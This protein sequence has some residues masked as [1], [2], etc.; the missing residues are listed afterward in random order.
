[1]IN[2]RTFIFNTSWFINTDPHKAYMTC[3]IKHNY[4]NAKGYNLDDKDII[5]TV[6]L[7][8]PWKTPVHWVFLCISLFLSRKGPLWRIS[9]LECQ[10]HLWV[11]WCFGLLG[12][13]IDS[14]EKYKHECC[15][16]A[17]SKNIEGGRRLINAFFQIMTGI[18]SLDH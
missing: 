8:G 7:C 12:G 6:P 2:C 15:R 9:P 13:V 14:I 16:L 10:V 17:D 3:L 18:K 4:M 5:Y 11:T 1:M